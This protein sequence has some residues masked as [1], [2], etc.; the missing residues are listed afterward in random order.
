MHSL[1][2]SSSSYF[3]LSKRTRTDSLATRN[4][5]IAT[6]SDFLF[7]S[8]I[9]TNRYMCPEVTSPRAILA[10][11]LLLSC[12]F[13]TLPEYSGWLYVRSKDLVGWSSVTKNECV[14]TFLCG[15]LLLMTFCVPHSRHQKEEGGF[16]FTSKNQALGFFI[17][18]NL[19]WFTM[20]TF[21]LLLEEGLPSSWIRLLGSKA[22]WP[23]MFDLALIL[24]PVQCMLPMLDER[25]M[26]TSMPRETLR[27]HVWCGHAIVLWL[28]L[29]TILLTWHYFSRMAGKNWHK[30]ITSMVP[31][32]FPVYTKGDVNFAGW[33]SLCTLT[34][35]WLA[36]RPS[37]QKYCYELFYKIHWVLGVA[38][39]VG[40]HLHDYN[41]WFFVQPAFGAW[42][43]DWFLRPYSSRCIRITKADEDMTIDGLGRPVNDPQDYRLTMKGATSSPVVSLTFPIPPSWPTLEPGMFLYLSDSSSKDGPPHPF[44]INSFTSNTFTIHIKALG[45][46]TSSY[47]QRQIM[48]GLMHQDK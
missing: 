16:V 48:P 20:A 2:S 38:F 5:T 11:F 10:L 21:S 22:A 34:A 42:W 36:A 47:I 23:A 3:H 32:Y 24:F 33:V 4:S 15:T 43:I 40:A 12:L 8:P 13:F 1:E 46:W 18:L 41:V 30:F 7:L 9:R 27:W 25:G 29:H 19:L 17:G 45:D 44:S 31:Y 28:I 35:L 26:G 39:V 37:V 6:E 14:W